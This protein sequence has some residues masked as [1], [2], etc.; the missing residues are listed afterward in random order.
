M[1]LLAAV[2]RGDADRVRA[3]LAEQP[4]AVN[5]KGKDGR[6]PLLLAVDA[7]EEEVVDALLEAGAD[8]TVADKS[9]ATP[10][11]LALEAGFDEI[12]RRLLEEAPEQLAR[13][14]SPAGLTVAHYAVRNKMRAVLVHLVERFPEPADCAPLVNAAEH[15]SGATPLHLAVAADDEDVTR[16]LVERAG[17]D[18]R[19]VDKEGNAPLHLAVRGGNIAIAA[20]LLNRGAPPSQPN[21]LGQTPLHLAFELTRSADHALVQLL[22][23]RGADPKAK[24]RNGCTPEEVALAAARGSEEE[25]AAAD[26]REGGAVARP[27]RAAA[28]Q[29]VDEVMLGWLEANGLTQLEP[30]FARRRVN[31]TQVR[32]MDAAQLRKIGVPNEHIQA[33]L[34]AILDLKREDQAAEGR[35]AEAAQREVRERE[36]QVKR[37]RYGITLAVLLFFVGFYAFLTLKMRK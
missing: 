35:A 24:D 16:L 5:A 2:K 34:D 31:L 12:A 8:A 14:V 1:S 23:S 27:K 26:G 21:G 33:T 32:D 15:A 19:A 3:L 13:F 37:M 10:L 11:A 6:T 25:G 22:L 28:R 36:A 17:A 20:F 9:G 7:G 4:E 30:V 18:V 29:Q